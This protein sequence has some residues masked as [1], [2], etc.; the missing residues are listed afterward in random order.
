MMGGPVTPD[1]LTYFD[2]MCQR[3]KPVVWVSTI[4]SDGRPHLVPSCFV[5]PI[6]GDRVAIGCVFISQT[7]KNVSRNQNVTI[8]A[9]RFDNGY[10]GYMIKGTAQVLEEGEVFDEMKEAVRAASN[11]RR[12]VR[13][14][15][16]VSIKDVYSL[17]PGSGSKKVR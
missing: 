14:V 4:S 3:E 11:G 16:L 15:L 9:T 5:K 13:H 7:V 17:K 10:D 2:N 8:G 1:F 6:G 12:S